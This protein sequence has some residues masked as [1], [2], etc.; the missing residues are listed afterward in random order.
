MRT[1]AEVKQAM[2]LLARARDNAK[3]KGHEHGMQLAM[4]VDLLKWVNGEHSA[5]ETQLFMW[6]SIVR[7]LDAEKAAGN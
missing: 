2:A 4:F 5:F 6:T 1:E 3:S 7:A